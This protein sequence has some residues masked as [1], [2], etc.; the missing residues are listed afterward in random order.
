MFAAK[1]GAARVL[2]VDNSD[3]ITKAREI[4]KDNNLD[5]IIT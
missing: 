5:H 3:I 1:A 2:S 4:V